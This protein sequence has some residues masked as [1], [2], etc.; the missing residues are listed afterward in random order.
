MK[1]IIAFDMDGTIADLYSV[2]AWLEK[3]RRAD[4]SPYL[5]AVPLYDMDKLNHVCGLLRQSGYEIQVITALS[6]GATREYKQAIRSA[7]REWLAKYGFIYDHFHG[8]DYSTCK[9]EVLRRD[10]RQG[11]YAVLVDDEKRHR[12]KWTWG[13]TIIP[14]EFLFENLYKLL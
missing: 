8:V 14:N 6:M 10:M 1:K 11:G 3:L 4:A 5:D 7:K 13:A 9:R 2:A 12:E